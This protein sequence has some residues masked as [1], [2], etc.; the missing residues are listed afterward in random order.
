MSD[1][2]SLGSVFFTK[3]L[4]WGISFST[5]VNVALVAKPRNAKD[6]AFYF[7]DF[8]IRICFLTSP[9]VSGIFLSASLI[10]FSTDLIY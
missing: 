3:L 7:N 2:F 6:F 8:S 4:T 10:F 1:V 9:L 5:A